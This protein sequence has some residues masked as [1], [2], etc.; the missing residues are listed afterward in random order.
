MPSSLT[1]APLL[2]NTGGVQRMLRSSAEVVWGAERHAVPIHGAEVKEKRF[3]TGLGLEE[4][5]TSTPLM[6][7]PFDQA[8]L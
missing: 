2:K 7:T 4:S 5:H 6:T 8:G 3:Q 1:G